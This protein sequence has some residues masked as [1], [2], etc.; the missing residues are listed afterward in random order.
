M[1]CG[2]TLTDLHVAFSR[3]G[4]KKYVQHLIAE[5]SQVLSKMIYGQDGD[6]VEG[7]NLGASL[8]VCG[9]ARTMAKSVHQALAD[10]V[11]EVY[12]DSMVNA[13]RYQ[14]DVWG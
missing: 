8:Y 7:S 3:T 9:N 2:R 4:N 6:G 14:R 1:G 10:V 5:Q 12:L 13:R 11:G